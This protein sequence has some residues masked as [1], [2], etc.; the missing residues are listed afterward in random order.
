MLEKEICGRDD[1]IIICIISYSNIRTS[2]KLL[3]YM[4][5]Y[6]NIVLQLLV[7][8][9]TDHIARLKIRARS[10]NSCVE[11]SNPLTSTNF[12]ARLSFGG[13]VTHVGLV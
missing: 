13:W 10:F 11:S 6:N 8:P 3:H 1:F 9:W 2:T 5:T 12:D 7:G 4:T